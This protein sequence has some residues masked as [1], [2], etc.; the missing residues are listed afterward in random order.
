MKQ[1]DIALIAV[2]AIISAVLSIVL[3]NV[4]LGGPDNKQLKAEVVDK[5]TSDFPKP[6]TKYFNKDSVNPSRTIN[7]GDSNNAAPFSGGN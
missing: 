5:V 6:D 4:L 3:S 1:K 7:I 2:V